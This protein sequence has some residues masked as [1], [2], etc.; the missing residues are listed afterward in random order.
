MENDLDKSGAKTSKIQAAAYVRMS[1]EHQQ[2]ST[3]NQ[4]DVIRV[5]AE[6]NNMEITRIYSDE[7]KS[8]VSIKRRVALQNMLKDVQNS[9]VNYQVILVYDVSRWGRF[10]DADE[11][12][13]YEYICRRSGIKIIYCAEQFN[14]DGSPISAIVKNIKRIM[15]AEYSRELSQKVYRGKIRLVGLGYWQGGATVYGLRRMLVDKD[16]KHKFILK[17]G[18]TKSIQTDRVVLVPGPK[19]EVE[20]IKWIFDSFVNK[21]FTERQIAALLNERKIK[22]A[23]A[24]LWTKK[25][26]Q[27]VLTNEAYMGN[28]VFGKE[29]KKFYEKNVRQKSEL[30]TRN[31]GVYEPIIN[32]KLFDKAQKILRNRNRKYTDEEL[33]TILRNIYLKNGKLTTK[34]INSYKDSPSSKIY[35]ER[36]GSLLMAYELVGYQVKH[37][38]TF[39]MLDNSDE[40]LLAKLKTLY[41]RSGKLTSVLINSTDNM[42]SGS[43]YTRR[44]GSL[45][46]A[47]RLVGYYPKG[48]YRFYGF[49]DEELLELVRDIYEKEGKLSLRIIQNSKD[50]PGAHTYIKRFGSLPNV[51]DLVGFKGYRN[52]Y[53]YKE[54]LSDKKLLTK[55]KKLHNEHGKLTSRIINNAKD[56]LGYEA[57]KHRFGGMKE[58]RELVEKTK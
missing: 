50:C 55:L 57:C 41:K 6:C 58:I 19:K 32:P 24:D 33:I 11:A 40:E 37:D 56:C 7:G 21:R 51:Y 9:Q 25:I 44:F 29:S 5:Y 39:L 18:E 36:F 10:Q 12:A 43:V 42:L 53:Y 14:N 48:K 54:N 45:I 49:S 27:Y 8:G 22:P 35:Q 16:G 4:L 2:Y 15:A 30:W 26:V 38:Y 3:M 46:N 47:Y 34:I 23:N 31:N 52:S 17:K 1:T 13:Y 28:L 20:I